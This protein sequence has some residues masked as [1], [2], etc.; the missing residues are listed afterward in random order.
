MFENKTNFTISV[1]EQTDLMQLRVAKKFSDLRARM[2]AERR[3]RN[4]ADANQM[5][6]QGED[7]RVFVDALL[8][9]PKATKTT[10]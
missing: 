7:R 1:G 10:R 9:P 5:T 6:L 2:S 8:N 3:A 4:S